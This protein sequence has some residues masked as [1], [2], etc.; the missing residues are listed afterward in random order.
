MTARARPRPLAALGL[1]LAALAALAAPSLGR[2]D[3]LPPAPPPPGLPAPEPLPPPPPAPVAP[4]PPVA[5]PSPFSLERASSPAD[6]RDEGADGADDAHDGARGDA[7]T[8]RRERTSGR[9]SPQGLPLQRRGLVALELATFLAADQ[10]GGGPTLGGLALRVLGSYPVTPKTFLEVRVPF[11]LSTAGTGNVMLGARRALTLAR[12]RDWLDVG[13]GLGLPLLAASA[14]PE[15]YAAQVY[16]HALWNLHEYYPSSVPVEL[17]L[18]YERHVGLFEGRLEL[19]PVLLVPIDQNPEVELLVQ[20]AVELQLGHTVGFGVRL[21][22]VALP[23]FERT[24]VRFPAI[25]P[26]GPGG[27]S[28]DLY[29]SALE[30]FL[31]IERPSL[32]GRMG[33]M[34]PLDELLGPPFANVWGFRLST[35]ARF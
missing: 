25:T 35:G 10:S 14:S 16:P 24:F 20:H 21:Q 8:P 18:R 7:P 17:R 30:P 15:L 11:T 22:G 6:G 34:M 9:L 31:V 27:G 3:E 29:Q 2:A 5:P 26:S 28:N 19:E 1:M 13:V 33:V 23:T 12:G 32:F 4:P